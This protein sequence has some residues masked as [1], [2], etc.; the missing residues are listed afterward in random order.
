M[1]YE[2]DIASNAKSIPQKFWSYA[3]RKTSYK[4]GISHLQIGVCT[5]EDKSILTAS[6][7][8]KVQVLSNFFKGC[9]RLKILPI[10]HH[11]S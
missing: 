7:L 4:Q 1:L 2:K 10:S 8:E 6:D 5:D 11:W 3:K 9:L